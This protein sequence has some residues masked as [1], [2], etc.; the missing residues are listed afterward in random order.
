MVIVSEKGL[1]TRYVLIMFDVINKGTRNEILSLSSLVGRDLATIITSWCYVYIHAEVIAVEMLELARLWIEN[2]IVQDLQWC[3]PGI[4][5]QVNFCEAK[6]PLSPSGHQILYDDPDCSSF[7]LY[8]MNNLCSHQSLN[9]GAGQRVSIALRRV[10]VCKCLNMSKITKGNIIY[11][12]K[13]ILIYYCKYGVF[14]WSFVPVQFLIILKNIWRIWC[15]MWSIRAWV[16]YSTKLD[17]YSN[18]LV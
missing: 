10:R 15:L 18:G 12:Y 3:V 13:N 4:V 17:G 16:R 14:H 11:L 9:E 7:L 5:Q 2:C 1:V 8:C 6:C